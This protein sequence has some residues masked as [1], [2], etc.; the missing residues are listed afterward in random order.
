[1]Y[2]RTNESTLCVGKGFPCEP[3][4]Q[5]DWMI[6]YFGMYAGYAGEMATRKW[7]YIFKC[8]TEIIVITVDDGTARGWVVREDG[9]ERYGRVIASIL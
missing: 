8:V 5:I 4:E 7:E 3:L 6:H 1:M 9:G 2:V